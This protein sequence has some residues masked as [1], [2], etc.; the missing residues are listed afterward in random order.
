MPGE[1]LLAYCLFRAI[2]TC[3]GNIC[4]L[5]V[6]SV[7]L[8]QSTSPISYR[9]SFLIFEFSANFLCQSLEKVGGYITH[10]F[11]LINSSDQFLYEF[12]SLSASVHWHI[13]S[14][15]CWDSSVKSRKFVSAL[16]ILSG[17]YYVSRLNWSPRDR[18]VLRPLCPWQRLGQYWRKISS[19]FW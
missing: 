6:C 8:V 18:S 7:L 12:I 14:D 13:K 15:L 16:P 11:F 9:W 5:T 4:W 10:F 2:S 19:I 3:L 1:Y 17:W